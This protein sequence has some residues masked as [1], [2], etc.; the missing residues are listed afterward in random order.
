MQ[1]I[2]EAT[3]QKA[4]EGCQYEIAAKQQLFIE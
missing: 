1:Q 3:I 4:I 2:M